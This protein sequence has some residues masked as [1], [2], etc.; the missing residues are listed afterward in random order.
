MYAGTG[1]L[2]DTVTDIP[3]LRERSLA[4]GGKTEPIEAASNQ[5]P[6]SICA[7]FERRLQ[8]VIATYEK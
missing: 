7:D 8:E 2:H 4:E 6:A 1:I 5:V 3:F